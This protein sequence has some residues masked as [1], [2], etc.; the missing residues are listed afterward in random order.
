MISLRGSRQNFHTV[1]RNPFVIAEQHKERLRQRRIN[2]SRAGHVAAD[3]FIHEQ[4][5]NG[6]L[7]CSIGRRLFHRIIRFLRLQVDGGTHLEVRT[8]RIAFR[9][10]YVER[11]FAAFDKLQRRIVLPYRIQVHATLDR[12]MAPAN[13][14]DKTV[15]DKDPYVIVPAEF[16]VLAFHVLEL[17]RNLH[18][19]AV[20][21]TAAAYFPVELRIGNRPRRIEILEIVNRIESRID[22]IVAVAFLVRKVR[23]PKTFFVQRQADVTTNTV[24]V[25][26]ARRIL[27]NHLRNEPLF[28]F[29]CRRAQVPRVFRRT[30]TP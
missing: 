13:I 1:R 28:N 4:L 19:K 20:I 12:A 30:P 23:L 16:K 5:Q 6:I 21:V 10:E 29:V 7:D 26:V 17:R 27:C 11:I 24:L 9:E 3:G 14:Y 25:F 8:R 22:G 2:V 18:R 15:V